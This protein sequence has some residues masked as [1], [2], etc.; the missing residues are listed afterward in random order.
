MT[1]I[2]FKYAYAQ[3]TGLGHRETDQVCQDAFRLSIVDGRDGTPWI[4]AVVADGVGSAE[5]AEMGSQLAAE[6]FDR[7]MKVSLEEGLTNDLRLDLLAA[8]V[9]AR[10]HIQLVAEA[11]GHELDA[12]G[13]TLLGFVTNGVKTGVVQIGDGAIVGGAGAD[14]KLLIEPRRAEHINEN[15]FLTCPTW[16]EALQCRI[17]TGP[18]D[19]AVLM[20]DGLEDVVITHAG[21]HAGFFGFVHAALAGTETSGRDAALC[22]RL[23]QLL[24][25]PSVRSRTHDDTTVIAIQTR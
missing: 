16:G 5:H 4:I 2:P 20:S 17:I 23:D 21:P 13:T 19:T 7:T 15:T 22:E 25:G 3:A 6:F 24:D 18:I 14:W 10:F 9:M 8:V 1:A 12:Y 11:K